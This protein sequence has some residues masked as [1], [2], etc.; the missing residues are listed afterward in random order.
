MGT[1]TQQVKTEKL[2]PVAGLTPYSGVF[3][4]EQII[5]LLK[6]TMFGAKRS[7]IAFFQGKTLNEVVDILTTEPPAL[8]DD[9]MPLKSYADPT[10][11]PLTDN[12]TIGQTW[13]FAPENGNF[14]GQRRNSLKQWWGSQML[15]QTRSVFEKMV[16]FWHNHFATEVV[17]T[18]PHMFFEH[19]MLLRSR[20]LGNFKLLTKDI[21]YDVCMLRY[22]N[23]YLNRKSA[24]DENY[25]RE[26]FELFTLGKGPNSRYTEDDVKAAAKLLTGWNNISRPVDATTGKYRYQVAFNA[27]NHD[28]SNKQFSAFFG[29]RLIPGG[30]ATETVARRE[31]DDLLDMTFAINEVSLHLC[32]KI[33]RYFVYYDI[34]ATIEA[35]V[36]APMAEIF[37]Q[38]NYEIKPVLKALFKSDHFFEVAQKACFIKTPIDYCVGFAREF[39]LAFP[40]VTAA[41]ITTDVPAFYNALEVIIGSTNNGAAVQAQNIGDPPNVS[42]WPAYYQEPVFHEAWINTD[43]FP[44]RLRYSD[45][46]LNTANGVAIRGT[47]KFLKVNSVTYTDAFGPDISD[48]NKLIDMALEALYRVPPTTAMR[49]YLK[50]NILLGGQASDH[51]WTDAWNAYKANP[52]TANFNVVNTRLQQ[53]YQ[54][55][56]RNPEYQLS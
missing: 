52:T 50:T 49:N 30:A 31:I 19:L 26:F 21:T 28:T 4:K 8:T 48:P 10:N 11:P 2:R 44:K 37:R 55:I 3:G 23:G 40:T 9:K 16:L 45:A 41:T 20:A 34:D 12:L 6:R 46:M 22:L 35:D 54:F 56:V 29:S 5:H 32:R 13:V 24:P 25:A 27:A 53:F 33:Y 18:T 14:N 7:D 47:T 1:M 17:D 51:Y 36:I 42:G 43:T 38:S 39:D 15:N